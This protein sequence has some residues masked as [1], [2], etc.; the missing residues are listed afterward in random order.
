MISII[1]FV[2]DDVIT[3]FYSKVMDVF[4]KAAEYME[5]PVRRTDNEPLQ[6]LFMLVRSELNLDLKNIKQEQAKFW[7]QHP[8]LVKVICSPSFGYIKQLKISVLVFN[9]AS[10]SY[11]FAFSF[12]TELLIQAQ[13][14]RESATLSP[15]LLGDFRRV[16]ELS[17]RL[18]EE[19]MKVNS[20]SHLNSH[21]RVLILM[22]NLLCIK[23][24]WY[25]L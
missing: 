8:S 24:Q 7:K 25:L 21:V 11:F 1:S 19:L 18:L 5:I 4:I 15:A 16:L 6:K 12:Q 23:K 13:L 10:A 2:Y 9:E 17:P 20:A 14:T 3:W 22:M